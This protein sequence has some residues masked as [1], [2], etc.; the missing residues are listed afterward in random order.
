MEDDIRRRVI[1]HDMGVAGSLPLQDGVC[2][3]VVDGTQSLVSCVAWLEQYAVS[4]GGL[5]RLDILCH[6]NGWYRDDDTSED[7]ATVGGFGLCITGNYITLATVNCLEPLKGLVTTIVIYSCQAARNS[8]GFTPNLLGNGR[9]LMYR[10]GQH[11]GA[12]V[13]ASDYD[14]TYYNDSYIEFRKWEGNLN[15]FDTDGSVTPWGLNDWPLT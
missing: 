7:P 11:T 9:E 12:Y 13:L 15:G 10:I 8:A 4:V 5:D 2:N 3:Y 1:W 6:G 14:Q